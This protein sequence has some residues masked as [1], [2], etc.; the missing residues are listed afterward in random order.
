MAP[1][2]GEAIINRTIRLLK[3]R[4][5]TD[6]YVTVR[7]PNQYGDLG[8]KEYI[9]FEQNQFNIDRLYGARTP[10]FIL[11]RLLLP[12]QAMDILSIPTLQILRDR[13]PGIIKSKQEIYYQGK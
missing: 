12:E 9:N 11:R 8:I 10:L 2:N 1:I 7:T 3:E 4:G 6:I 13:K 5:I